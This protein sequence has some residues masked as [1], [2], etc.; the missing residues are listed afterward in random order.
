MK[1]TFSTFIIVFALVSSIAAAALVIQHHETDIY[2]RGHAPVNIVCSTAGISS[3]CKRSGVPVQLGTI[4][5]TPTQ[6]E[7]RYLETH[8]S[9][10]DM[11]MFYSNRMAPATKA[12]RPET[13]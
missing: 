1:T 4:V 5:V 8:E 7:R 12:A 11:T 3:G 13:G 10:S 9:L 6:A 2:H